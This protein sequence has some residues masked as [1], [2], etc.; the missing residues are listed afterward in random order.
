MVLVH[1]PVTAVTTLE[2]LVEDT[3]TPKPSLHKQVGSILFVLL[4]FIVVSLENVV[5]VKDALVM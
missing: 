3:T 2:V 1:V 4:V 5:V